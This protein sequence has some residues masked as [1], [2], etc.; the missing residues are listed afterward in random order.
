MRTLVRR[1][2]KKLDDEEDL[3]HARVK[4]IFRDLPLGS[5]SATHDNWTSAANV[6]YEAVTLHVVVGG[7][8]LEMAAGVRP[9]EQNDHG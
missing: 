2:D 3:E 1:V 9:T 6:N 5:V 8:L 7:K 4:N